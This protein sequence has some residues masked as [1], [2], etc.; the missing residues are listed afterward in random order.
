VETQR[1]GALERETGG[2]GVCRRRE[3]TP[4]ASGRGDAAAAAAAADDD[5]PREERAR[6][7]SACLDA[8]GHRVDAACDIAEDAVPR[9]RRRV[10][11]RRRSWLLTFRAIRSAGVPLKR[12]RRSVERVRDQMLKPRNG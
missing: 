4:A 7:R 2:R 6:P 8:S 10:M 3:E 12:V 9:A 11:R 5:A 1:V